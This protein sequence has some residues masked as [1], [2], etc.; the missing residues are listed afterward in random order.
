MQNKVNLALLRAQ[1]KLELGVAAVLVF[2]ESLLLCKP[3][4]RKR[5]LRGE[6]SLEWVLVGGFMVLL[7][8]TA[9]VMVV[10]PNFDAVIKNIMDIIVKDTGTNASGGG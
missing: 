6:V 3:A 1:L 2:L 4:A 5:A 7:I 9:M 8:G 10:K